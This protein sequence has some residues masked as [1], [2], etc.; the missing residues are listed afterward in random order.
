MPGLAIAVGGDVRPFE[1]AMKTALTIGAQTAAQI[2][3]RYA[4][5]AAGIDKAFASTARNVG[6]TF[7]REMAGALSPTALGI[8]GAV[9]GVLALR[10]AVDE[11]G[12]AAKAAQERLEGMVKIGADARAAGVGTTFL[13]SLTGQAKALQVEVSSLTAMLDTAREAS[14][15]RIAEGDGDASSTILNRLQQNLKAG[16]LGQ[17]DIERFTGAESQESRIRVILD[18][19][20]Q[21]RAKGA[22]LA[23]L[24]LART[25]FGA[26]FETKLRTGTDMIGAMRRALD[27]LAIG[28]QGRII[29][30]EEIQ[31]AENLNRRL[32]EAQRI[33]EQG[34]API[35]RDIA[36][37]QSQ[38]LAGWVDIKEQIA[39]AAAQAGRL[40]EWVT[41]VGT[42]LSNLGNA[43][44]FKG[45]RDALD[46]M[47]M[48]DKGEVARIERMLNGGLT[49]TDAPGA[50][51]DASA[52]GPLQIA[53]KP[54]ADTSRALPSLR[55]PRAATA[56]SASEVSAIETFVGSLEKS[57]AALRAEADAY[58]RSN[59]ERRIAIELAK[60]EEIAKQNN[61]KL[62][63]EQTRRIREAAT[64]AAEQRDRVDDLRDRQELLRSSAGDVFHGLYNDAKNGASGLDLL[65]NALG[66]VLDRIAGAQID[67]LVDA[68]L[69]K[70]GTS[71]ALSGLFGGGNPFSFV[72]SLIG[73]ATGGG[74]GSFD[75]VNAGAVGSFEWL[76]EGGIAGAGSSTRTFPLSVLQGAPR[77]H[78]GNLGLGPD[79]IP[80]I[81]QRGEPVLSRRTAKNLSNAIGTLS[82]MQGGGGETTVNVHPPAGTA[83]QVQKR[84]G[85]NGPTV[86]V[87]I[88]SVVGN[89]LAA[90][91]PLAQALQDT[92][93]LNRMA[94]KQS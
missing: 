94:G 71:G 69:G 50:P 25:M 87:M 88:R 92:Y 23:A 91:G 85:S 61:V 90:N 20:E 84:R 13:Q 44:V 24:D 14:T 86:D 31:R 16:N 72:T 10:F 54:K 51:K 11:V 34:L 45:L 77:F 75:A 63:E 21:L 15:I 19:L 27:G 53:V 8:A 37:W 59:V 40:Y 58:G 80:A 17:A 67:G 41:G 33:L 42:V 29:A 46:N 4:A 78:K 32:E 55:T 2:G 70:N 12:R 28:D 68:L 48:I 73:G 60:A 76:H 74:G 81:L 66:R 82:E 30:P 52:G 43:N 62:T 47:G 39:A 83:P 56:P 64:A 93:G 1:Q 22:N 89:D 18:L 6:V 3:A 36:L 79:E 49:A 7:G 5:A 38:Q 65:N 26:E 35:N 57:A 9:A